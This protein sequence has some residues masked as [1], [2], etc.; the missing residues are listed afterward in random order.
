MKT[1]LLSTFMILFLEGAACCD[2]MSILQKDWDYLYSIDQTNQRYLVDRSIQLGEVKSAK[3]IVMEKLNGSC[4]QKSDL[5]IRC[6]NEKYA[7][8]LTRNKDNAAWVLGHIEV[9]NPSTNKLVRQWQQAFDVALYAPIT[10]FYDTTCDQALRSGDM[11][12]GKVDEDSETKVITFRYRA[13][14]RGIPGTEEDFIG[15]MKL[16][17]QHWHAIV[18]CDLQRT[19]LT[20][21]SPSKTIRMTKEYGALS[22]KYRATSIIYNNLEKKDISYRKFSISSYSQDGMESKG[23]TLSG[24]DLPEAINAVPVVASTS[25]FPQLLILAAIAAL[26]AVLFAYLRH[27][28]VSPKS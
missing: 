7:F 4:L 14:L 18:E 6:W 24:F 27:R 8:E 16:D 13:S 28:T 12:L 9:D 15:K 22:G 10:A 21:P 3:S 26:L 11:V 25:Y 1:L 2:D 23:F 20:T 19:K 17:K 5:A